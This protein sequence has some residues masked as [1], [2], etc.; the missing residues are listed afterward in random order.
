M[1]PD[2]PGQDAVGVAQ[3][4]L[5]GE[6][7]QGAGGGVL[8]PAASP[9]AGAGETLIVDAGVAHLTGHAVAAVENLSVVNDPGADAGAQGDG[10]KALAALARSGIVLCQG[11]AVGVVFHIQVQPQPPLEQL[12]Q[13]NVPQG[14]VAGVYDGPGADVHH[15]RDAR[16]HGGDLLH[17]HAALL[18]QLPGQGHQGVRQ[19]VGVRHLTDLHGFHGQQTA[20]LVHKTGLQVGAAD[21]DADIVH[22]FSLACRASSSIFLSN[23]VMKSR[24]E[25]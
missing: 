15:S 20:V 18:G 10:D 19:G 23:W 7:L 13:G 8:L 25:L 2:D 14:Q 21:V 6:A 11:G 9:A 22:C 5:G 16:P 3:L 17:G 12:A 1:L 4:G 24:A